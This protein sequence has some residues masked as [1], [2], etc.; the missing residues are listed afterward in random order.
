MQR[1]P[2]NF[3]EV[4]G[5][6][7]EYGPDARL[8]GSRQRSFGSHPQGNISFPRLVI[9]IKKVKRV[10][11]DIQNSGSVHTD[12]RINRDGG[13]GDNSAC[14]SIFF[15]A[16]GGCRYGWFGANPY[17]RTL[18][19][20]I[21]NASP[22]ADTAPARLSTKPAPIWQAK[23]AVAVSP[24]RSFLLWPW[25]DNLAARRNSGSMTCQF[26]LGVRRAF[27]RLTRRRGVDLATVSACCQIKHSGETL[28]AFG[29]VGPRPILVVDKKENCRWRC[30]R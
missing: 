21:C 13:I 6:L 5:L 20:N 19:G 16:G 17:R 4:L 9:D 30:R 1:R 24:S 22:A 11:S 28:F 7:T 18:G 12:W 8:V 29:A 3:D 10:R 26:H 23:M 14:A 27:A 25:K 2:K 15:G